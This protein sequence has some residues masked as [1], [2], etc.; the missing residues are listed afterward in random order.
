[1]TTLQKLASGAAGLALLAGCIDNLPSAPSAMIAIDPA[2]AEAAPG[3]VAELQSG[4]KAV[5]ATSDEAPVAVT[6]TDDGARLALRGPQ[7][8]MDRR[9]PVFADTIDLT[10][11]NKEAIARVIATRAAAMT[12]AVSKGEAE[13]ALIEDLRALTTAL[14]PAREEE[15]F[16]TEL[17]DDLADSY[18]QGLFQIASETLADEDIQALRDFEINEDSERRGMRG[19]TIYSRGLAYYYLASADHLKADESN[20]RDVATAFASFKS[21]QKP[22]RDEKTEEFVAARVRVGQLL[23]AA[24]DIR[25]EAKLHE[26]AAY[27]FSS[28]AEAWFEA[29]G[30]TEEF[31]FSFSPKGKEIRCFP[32]P[33]AES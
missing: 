18:R 33:V 15:G 13:D 5:I 30:S 11:D 31:C 21:A 20:Q 28:A 22:F 2:F 9:D 3:V 26:E 32:S 8:L 16:D 27:A 24:A 6:L 7:P 1:M 12:V 17:S 23:A 19:K 10:S 4:F 25:D 29:T 14:L